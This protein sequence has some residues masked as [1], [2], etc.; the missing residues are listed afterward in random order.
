MFSF[1]LSQPEAIGT[2]RLIVLFSSV[3]PNH[4]PSTSRSSIRP[5]SHDTQVLQVD[6]V[7]DQVVSVFESILE[8]GSEAIGVLLPYK[9]NICYCSLAERGLCYLL[10]SC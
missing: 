2:T 3:V 8:S 7:L 4:R 9:L 6:S 10:T 5:L 1:N